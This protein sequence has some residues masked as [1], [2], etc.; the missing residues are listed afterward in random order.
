MEPRVRKSA[1]E[2]KAEIIEVTLRLAGEV[3]PDRLT[4]EALAKE[5]GISKPG[6]FRHFPTKGAI[7]EAVG[8]HIGKL[9]QTK[10][11]LTK[12]KK[13]ARPIDELRDYFVGHLRFIETTPAIPAIL[14]SRE[15]H[16]EN[17]QLRTFFAG[18]IKS[19]H[20]HFSKLIAAEIKAGHFKKTIDPDDA[21]YLILALVQGLAMRWS[22]NNRSF[23]LPKEGQRLLEL[24]LNGFEKTE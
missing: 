18:L 14:F 3:G 17:D 16:A 7:W 6:I 23:D 15:L 12:K 10:I 9:M 8:Q 5:V 22:L 20:A 4:T 1:K 13:N 11:A 2:R 24:Q 19:R 21:A